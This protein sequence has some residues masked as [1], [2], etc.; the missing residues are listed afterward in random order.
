MSAAIDLDDQA[1]PF[2]VDV[3]DEPDTSY[4]V[5]VSVTKEYVVW[6]EAVSIAD[7]VRRV[8]NDPEWYERI[9]DGENLATFW[10]EIRRPGGEAQLPSSTRMDWELIYQDRGDGSYQGMRADA[11][12]ETHRYALA[13]AKR[14]ADR[15]AC[16]AAG[17][18]FAEI[19][20]SATEPYCSICGY[21]KAKNLL[22]ELRS[23]KSESE[24]TA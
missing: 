1:E 7:A 17:H 16:V 6:V 18:P 24:V 14:E 23:A 5:I 21:L 3:L 2:D 9:K 19:L 8:R 11:H 20:G 4:P 10:E 12:V 13:A 22:A 15:A